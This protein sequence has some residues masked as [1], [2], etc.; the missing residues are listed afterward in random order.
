MTRDPSNQRIPTGDLVMSA[1]LA[2]LT[3][4]PGKGTVWNLTII[5]DDADE[6]HLTRL[7]IDGVDT[8]GAES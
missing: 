5:G 2:A 7:D 6:Y 1:M 4:G 3:E 8:E